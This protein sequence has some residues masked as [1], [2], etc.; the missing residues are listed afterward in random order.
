MRL[1]RNPGSTRLTL[2]PLTPPL[3]SSPLFDCLLPLPV[4]NER[5]MH[6]VELQKLN[7][8]TLGTRLD[9]EG[10]ACGRPGVDMGL[11]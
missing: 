5:E 6:A 11:A 10:F 9:I 3:F 8:A 7:N 2:Q 1:K 4:A